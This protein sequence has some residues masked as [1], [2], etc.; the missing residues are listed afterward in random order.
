MYSLL[1]V[2]ALSYA[3]AYATVCIGTLGVGLAKVFIKS[4]AKNIANNKKPIKNKA[5]INK[6]YIDTD[7]KCLRCSEN[8]EKCHFAPGCKNFDIHNIQMLK[9]TTAND[10]N[11]EKIRLNKLL[12]SLD[13]IKHEINFLQ[14]EQNLKHKL[15][16]K[17]LVFTQLLKENKLHEKNYQENIS[18]LIKLLNKKSL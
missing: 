7:N 9:F 15:H 5:L 6:Y 1:V 10:I 12:M 3:T 11:K 18:L 13:N 17:Q 8:I 16:A 14:N 4:G 2:G